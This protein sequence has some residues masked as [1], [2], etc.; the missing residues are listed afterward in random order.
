[1]PKGNL[2][3]QRYT[4]PITIVDEFKRIGIEIEPGT[5]NH[6]YSIAKVYPGTDASAKQLSV[7]DEIVSIDGRNLDD[8]DA[9]DADETLNGQVGTTKRVELGAAAVPALANTTIDVL[10]ED[11]IPPP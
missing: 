3:L 1:Y 9:I 11:L 7:G 4:S 6:R 8:L 10:V 5:G 2:Q